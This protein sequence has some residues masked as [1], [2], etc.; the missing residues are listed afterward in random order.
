MVSL[1]PCLASL[2]GRHATR[3]DCFPADDSLLCKDFTA[4]RLTFL[5]RQAIIGATALY[6]ELIVHPTQVLEG[7][8]WQAVCS[9]FFLVHAGP[10][11]PRSTDLPSGWR[12]FLPLHS[13][14]RLKHQHGLCAMPCKS[15]RIVLCLTAHPPHPRDWARTRERMG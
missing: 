5:F 10:I 6:G 3:R 1:S 7:V 9:A 14:S 11:P 8:R 12:R 13:T 15:S 2:T 4:P